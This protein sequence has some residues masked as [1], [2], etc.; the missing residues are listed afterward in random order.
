MPLSAVATRYANAMA[1]VVTAT[2][3][4]LRPQDAVSELRSFEAVL[5]SA[6]LHNALVT[7]A[8]PPG[9]K[10]AVVRRLG[11]IL[12]LSAVT[13]NFLYVLIDH[14]RMA[15]FPDIVEAF[16]LVLDER[17]GF[18]RAEVIAARDLDQSQRGALNAELEKVSGKRL[19]MRFEVNPALIG[20]V[21]ARIGS[22]VYDGS[23]RGQLQSLER[24]LAAES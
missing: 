16:E 4:S 18:A 7:P 9:R 21:V 22:T 13:R 24:R 15:E 14:R 5:R 6:E 12:K 19:R 23:V 20:G 11:E 3:S 2:G 8:I 17:L 1:D 10:R